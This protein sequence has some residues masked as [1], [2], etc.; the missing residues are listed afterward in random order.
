MNYCPDW[1]YDCCVASATADFLQMDMPLQAVSIAYQ[2][3]LAEDYALIDASDFAN[4]IQEVVLFLNEAEAG[5]NAYNL[6]L[7]FSFFRLKFTSI[8]DERKI[9]GWFGSAIS[10]D[11]SPK[12]SGEQTI[13]KFKAFLVSERHGQMPKMPVNWNPRQESEIDVFQRLAGISMNPLDIFS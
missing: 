9:K 4:T 13:K 1:L 3:A 11:K 12:F 7:H 2:K 5:E 10:G 8:N 6:C